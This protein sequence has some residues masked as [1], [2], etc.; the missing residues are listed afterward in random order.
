MKSSDPK[1][2][3]VWATIHR[4]HTLLFISGESIIIL[5]AFGLGIFGLPWIE[6]QLAGRD[7]V[8]PAYFTAGYWAFW[9]LLGLN[10]AMLMAHVF[11]VTGR[12]PRTMQI[13]MAVLSL[14]LP[15]ALIMVP[16][17]LYIAVLRSILDS[18]AS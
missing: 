6:G 10:L 7:G 13:A 2:D 8:V 15:V 1:S 11:R 16:I 3:A 4:V 5:I 18:L 14:L 17:L 9:S 12:G